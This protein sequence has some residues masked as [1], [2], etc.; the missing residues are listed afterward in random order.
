[1]ARVFKRIVLLSPVY[2][3]TPVFKTEKNGGLWAYSLTFD[4][5]FDEIVVSDG[6]NI[7]RLNKRSGTLDISAEEGL[8]VAVISGGEIVSSGASGINIDK[9]RFEKLVTPAYDDEAIATD[10]YYEAYNEQINENADIKVGA[11]KGKADKKSGCG[12]VEDD[13]C[14]RAEKE[15]TAD[16]GRAAPVEYTDGAYPPETC[17]YEKVASNIAALLKSGKSYPP[18]SRVIPLSRWV[19][20]S[21]GGKTYYFGLQ[22][23]PDYICY[24]VKGRRGDPPEGFENAFFVPENFFHETNDG[25]LISFQSAN[26]GEHINKKSR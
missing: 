2:G 9:S 19:E 25:Y 3:V 12:T 20:I 17:Y 1:M 21:D 22:G 18:L 5:S 7:G 8:A 16:G 13:A 23:A 6:T 10:N 14:I 15:Q 11:E 24:A 4:K 26:T